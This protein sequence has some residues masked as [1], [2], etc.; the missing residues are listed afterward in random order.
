MWHVS[1]R[2]GV[3]TLRT[4]IHLLLTYLL[5]ERQRSPITVAKAVDYPVGYAAR[6]DGF[7]NDAGTL[8]SDDAESKTSA[9]VDE[10]DYFHL[11]PVGVQLAS[12]ITPHSTLQQT[13]TQHSST[14]QARADPGLGKGDCRA[15]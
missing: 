1:S 12:H 2:S 9:I 14:T 8:A 13:G 6:E 7:D 15:A 11:R 5:C 4:A 3:A 10:S